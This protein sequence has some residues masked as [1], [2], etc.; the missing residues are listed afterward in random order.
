MGARAGWREDKQAWYVFVSDKSLIS[1]TN[2]SGRKA[3]AYGDDEQGALDCA[4]KINE[5][6]KLGKMAQDIPVLAAL[7]KMQTPEA[8]KEPVKT[9]L[10]FVGPIYKN[11]KMKRFELLENN[12]QIKQSTKRHYG[13]Q[14]RNQILPYLGDLPLDQ[15]DRDRV[16]HWLRTDLAQRSEQTAT[17][18]LSALSVVL[19]AALDAKV[20]TV[21]PARELAEY[22]KRANVIKKEVRACSEAELQ[23]FL[24]AIRD[25]RFYTRKDTE[26]VYMLFKLLSV[27]GLRIGEGVSLYRE[28][29]IWDRMW[30]AVRRTLPEND[31]QATMH[32]YA[33]KT[34]K[35]R[36]VDLKADFAPMLREYMNATLAEP[37]ALLFRNPEGGI[38]WP[39]MMRSDVVVP[40]REALGLNWITPHTMRHTYVSDLLSTGGMDKLYYVQKQLGHSNPEM[41]LRKYGHFIQRTEG[42]PVDALPGSV[43]PK[44]ATQVAK[45][46]AQTPIFATPEQPETPRRVVTGIFGRKTG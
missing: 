2:K 17:L 13:T 22:T 43:Q 6:L 24:Q 28:D 12:T 1:D 46:P 27:A 14:L 7:I 9:L 33:P 30:I 41:T 20:I 32:D 16:K 44:V 5:A 26:T 29:I 40:V 25:G 3:Y 37:T 11:D 15:I 18:A 21:H 23:A 4:V 36:Y 45:I 39:N 35:L 19:D 42:R 10:A 31:A 8:P 38:M 34:G